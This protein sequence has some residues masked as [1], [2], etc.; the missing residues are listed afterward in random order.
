MTAGS[1]A[2]G[3]VCTGAAE[4]CFSVVDGLS[5]DFT[6]VVSSVTALV[7]TSGVVFGATDKVVLSVADVVVG[8]FCTRN[9]F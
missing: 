8:V 3:V 4:V 1:V 6:V 9:I 2:T 7:V 5:V